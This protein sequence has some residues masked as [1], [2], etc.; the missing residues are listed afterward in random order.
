MMIFVSLSSS[1]K[2]PFIH[3]S[4]SIGHTHGISSDG[5]SYNNLEYENKNSYGSSI[6]P[7][8]AAAKFSN[9][10]VSRSPVDAKQK[11]VSSESD[12]AD[13]VFQLT[14]IIGTELVVSV[15][16]LEG[17]G[18]ISFV[19]DDPPP[20]QDG[21]NGTKIRGSWSCKK[22]ALRMMIE[23]QFI[24]RRSEYSVRSYYIARRAEPSPSGLLTVTGD[25]CD[26]SNDLKANMDSISGQFMITRFASAPAL[27]PIATKSPASALF[28]EEEIM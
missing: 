27:K 26:E 3:P 10:P 28:G 8:K 22:H 21:I 1:F 14:E 17:T 25:I 19:S 9:R 5:Q 15:I 4:A 12:I 20:L 16:H 23:R 7:L 11:I 13:K 18:E 2:L 24:G 6:L